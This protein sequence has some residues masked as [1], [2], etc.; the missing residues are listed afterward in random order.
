LSALGL[1]GVI[2]YEV[3]RRTREIG[4]RLAVGAQPRQIVTLFVRNG[5]A[6]VAAGCVVGG[7]LALATTRLLGAWLVGIRPRD[8]LTF[9]DAVASLLVVGVFACYIPARRALGVDP[10]VAL[11]HE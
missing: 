6:M 1:F 2:S 10:M 3:G 4:I 5:L 8:P 11:R 9:C 7:I